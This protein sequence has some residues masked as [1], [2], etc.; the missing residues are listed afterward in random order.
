MINKNDDYSYSLDFFGKECKK[1]YHNHCSGH[2]Q[3]LGFQVYCNCECHRKLVLD[4][5]ILKNDSNN[6]NTVVVELN[7]KGEFNK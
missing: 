6:E 7:N 4:K 2:W 1:N 5:P 3:G